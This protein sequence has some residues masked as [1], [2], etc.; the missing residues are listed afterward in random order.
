MDISSYSEG[1]IM[2]NLFA[3]MEQFKLVNPSAED[4]EYHQYFLT[5][6]AAYH[7]TNSTTPGHELDSM[8]DLLAALRDAAIGLLEGELFTLSLNIVLKVL[9]GH[10]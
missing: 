6:L 8:K 3:E 5:K 7:S 2:D 9:L 4:P 1:Q 10:L